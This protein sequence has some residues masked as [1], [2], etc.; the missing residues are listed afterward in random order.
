MPM[1]LWFGHINKRIFNPSEI[2]KGVRPVL[3]H[4]GRSSGH[5]FQTPLDAHPVENGFIFILMYGSGSD[6]VQNT[7]AS[8]AATLRTGGEDVD[9]EAPR[10][11]TKEVAWEQLPATTKAPPGFLRVTEYLQ[12]DTRQR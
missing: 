1:P 2:K 9:L 11:I 6:W 7:L 5:E 10:L 12:M 3:I 4:T 8:G